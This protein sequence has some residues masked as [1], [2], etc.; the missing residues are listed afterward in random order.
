MSLHNF[1]TNHKTLIKRIQWLLIATAVFLI[2]F[3]II[4]AAIPESDDTISE[5]IQHHTD[6]G[7]YTLVWIWGVLASHFFVVRKKRW[8]HEFL[9]IGII[10]ALS[11][12]IAFKQ[13]DFINFLTDRKASQIS[14][15]S[16][17]SLLCLGFIL[18]YI[19]WPQVDES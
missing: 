14:F 8:V 15:E 5:I 19:F 2:V 6:N 17:L 9:G 12:I 3:D 11:I 16:Y 10:L 18:G 4:L 13:Q 7:M 1:I